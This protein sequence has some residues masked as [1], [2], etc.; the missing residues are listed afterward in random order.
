MDSEI[1]DYADDNHLYYEDK[2]YNVLKSDLEN[3][4]IPA[5]AWFDNN[6]M[7]ANP[8]KFQSITL[9]RDG[10]QSLSISVEDNTI[11]SD[12]TIKVLGVTLD[13]GFD[14][15][16]LRLCKR[17]RDK[18]T[19]LREFQTTSIK[20][21]VIWILNLSSHLIWV[22]VLCFLCFAVRQTSVNWKS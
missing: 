19:H 9:S 22:I 8:D 13:N 17:R 21:V 14:K 5:T 18:L 16:V 12:T 7:Y 3:D 20:T 15:H 10:Q 1:A 2:S 6:Y 11:L 4:T